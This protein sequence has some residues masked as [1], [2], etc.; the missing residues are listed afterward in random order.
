VV[1]GGGT[2]GSEAALQMAKDGKKVTIVDILDYD[3]LA[4]D[5]PRGLAYQLE[6]HGVSFLTEMKLEEITDN[7]VMVVN[8]NRERIK[9]A[10]DS[11]I[12]SLGFKSLKSIADQF[13]GLAV[14]VYSIGDCVKPLSIKEA[15][16]GGFNVAVEI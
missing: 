11:V 15:I 4:G 5:W 7:G 9:V 13:K 12:L 3:L 6:D 1:I 2:T 14:D 8:K 10:A 16:H